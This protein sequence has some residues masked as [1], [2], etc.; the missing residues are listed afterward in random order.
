MES[1]DTL[2][3][4]SYSN[5][6][7]TVVEF[8]LKRQTDGKLLPALLCFGLLTQEETVLNERLITVLNEQV[9]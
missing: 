9:K 8:V 2:C 4:V 3:I 5:V 6:H 7:V 1:A